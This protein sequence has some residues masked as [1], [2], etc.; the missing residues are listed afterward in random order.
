MKRILTLL[1]VA[2]ILS[3]SSLYA[4]DEVRKTFDFG[5]FNA[6][7]AGFV[8]KI[9]VTKGKSN[10]IEVTCP[11]RFVEYLDYSVSGG[12]LKLDMEFP[13]KKIWQKSVNTA[14]KGEEI[15]V[16][17]QME[18]IKGISLSGVAD[19][20]A[21]GDFYAENFK[22]N[23]SGATSLRGNFKINANSL[24]YDL[25]GAC[26]C[27]INGQFMKVDGETSGAASFKLVGNVSASVGIEASGASNFNY[28]GKAHSINVEASGA[29]EVELE[30][31]TVFIGISCSGASDVDAEDMLAEEANASASGA[32]SIKV[33][34][35]NKMD[36]KTSGASE[37]KYYGPAKELNISEPSI[38][39]GE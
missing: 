19:F 25:S 38:K 23:M 14:Q 18:E 15:V 8:H 17:I 3:V 30:G 16:K 6:V 9:Y 37:I 34:G 35:N 2:I 21:Q 4:Q 36:L 20:T 26:E 7:S 33:Y 32:S 10:T 22:V 1:A 12:V 29:S 11:K 39:R 13:Q 5:E 31:S 24:V 27:S 28:K